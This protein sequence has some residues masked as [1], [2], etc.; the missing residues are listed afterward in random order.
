M[1]LKNK[2]SDLFDFCASLIMI[3][4]ASGCFLLCQKTKAESTSNIQESIT[5][6]QKKINQE[7]VA[8]K[9]L[10]KELN[11]IQYSVNATQQ[12]IKKT[13]QYINEAS[14]NISRHEEEIKL[15]EEK[16]DIEKA[17]LASLLRELYYSQ[18][19]MALTLAL[20]AQDSS[21]V[22]SNSDHLKSLEEKI[23]D[24][25]DEM[26]N[27]RVSIENNKSKLEETKEEHEKLLDLKQ[28]QQ[29]DLLD[30]KVETQG[31][32]KEKEATI[33]ELQAK[34][35]KLRSNLS[36]YLGKAY[37]AKDIED[38][39]NFA[40]KATGVRK[41]FIMGM[42]VVE[43]D[44]GRFTGGCLAKDSR[45]SGNRLTLFQNICDELDYNWK[46]RKVSCPPK[47]YKGTGGAMGVAQFMSD[48]WMGYKS[49]ISSK[50][51]HNPPDPWNLTDGVM[52]MGLKLARGGASSKSGECNAAKLYLSGTTSSKYNW[53]CQKVLYW[54]NNYQRL[55]D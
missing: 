31:D 3:L 30:A 16:V 38:A 1:E 43:S 36:S 20:S 22:F 13:Q 53:Y 55:L 8:K 50:T 45:M 48:T 26:R 11:Q 25:V 46:T 17:I 47:G 9:D 54:A 42:L 40:A 7:E 12:E 44:L 2:N 6:L 27:T 32:I 41:D 18:D 19:T 34:L 51:G 15:L 28:N 23:L 24:M 37:N 33:A 10:E 29:E 14:V 39:A 49:S 52:A 21:Q 5:S 35:D 4:A